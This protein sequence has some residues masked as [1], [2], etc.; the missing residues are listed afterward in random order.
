MNETYVDFDDVVYE[1]TSHFETSIILQKEVASIM[2]SSSGS[3]SSIEDFSKLILNKA[4]LIVAKFF[5]NPSIN[6]K[7][8]LEMIT[9]FSSIYK[10]PLKQLEI[11]Y[12][13]MKE[14]VTELSLI[15]S[16]F[17][18][19]DTEHR[20]FKYYTEK[21]T[22]INTI[23]R[24]IDTY[25]KS[26]ASKGKFKK[27]QG[28]DDVQLLPIIEL[29]E[30]FLQLPGVLNAILENITI[31]KNSTS[32]SSLFTGSL[33]KNYVLK[34]PDK[35]IIPLMVY[36]DDFE[37]NNVIGSRKVRKK[38]GA[39]YFTILGVPKEYASQLENI[40]VLQ[41]HKY[42][43]HRDL[44]NII[45]FRACID[46]LKILVKNG[47]K[48]PGCDK[49]LQFIIFQVVSDN[50]GANCILGFSKSFLSDQCCRMCIMN[51][52]NREIQTVED[53]SLL[54]SKEMY[55]K[56]FV[57]HKNGIEEMCIFNEIPYFHVTDNSCAD[58]C[59][60]LNE[61][62]GRYDMGKILHF[63]IVQEKHFSLD[64]LNERISCFNK[65]YVQDCNILPEIPKTCLD[66]RFLICSASKMKFL[67][68]YFGMLVGDLV[69]KPDKAWKLY[70]LLRE[71]SNLTMTSVVTE[72]LLNHLTLVIS[73]HHS[74]YKTL[75]NDTLKPKFHFVLHYP[76][77]MRKLGSLAQYSV[78][79][80]E[81]KHKTLKMIAD[82]MTSR[83]NPEYSLILKHQLQMSYRLLCK[84]G[85]EKRVEI[86]TRVM[87]NINMLPSM[88]NLNHKLLDY[89]ENVECTIVKWVRV[90][91]TLYKLGSVININKND[92]CIEFGRID[93][94][95]V[96]NS[97][98]VTFIYKLLKYVSH[99]QHLCG[100]EV[101]E[102]RR[103]GYINQS[104]L[105]N[106][107]PTYNHLLSDGK[108]YV[109]T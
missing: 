79:R 89:F 2:T 83:V 84:T 13:T 91:G 3:S 60:D 72:S 26:R 20:I 1:P 52:A 57:D 38:I 50:L 82:S 94:I 88:N 103:W 97:K 71:M 48:I 86:G 15:G 87:K 95:I 105:Y 106:F 19:F 73:K 108:F 98:E 58:P 25:L 92:S 12:S 49:P 77:L 24:P 68:E 22:L 51:K 7:T 10:I 8:V 81:G 6:R 67:I 35:I 65:L 40:F 69:P 32:F 101:V 36:N 56:D 102:G 54:R 44:G 93:H 64:T 85:F 41:L 109:A 37:V 66:N 11:K 30:N 107:V 28:H 33:Y 74:L 55:D 45:V 61:G 99:N 63:C 75:F 46:Q 18:T 90:N 80:F 34:I 31:L 17:D 9:S 100:Y 4:S 70:L 53:T 5:A 42:V 16:A 29:L 62:I 96:S 27:V 47:I 23:P 43:N 39:V 14:L 76:N 21:G 78:I 104:E 59:H